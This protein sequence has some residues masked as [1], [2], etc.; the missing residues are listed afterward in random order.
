LD[1]VEASRGLLVMERDRARGEKMG[2]TIVER[3]SGDCLLVGREDREFV[4]N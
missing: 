3:E 2:T 1:G 4:F